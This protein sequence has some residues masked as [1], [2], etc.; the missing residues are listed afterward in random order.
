[1]REVERDLGKQWQI[2]TQPIRGRIDGSLRFLDQPVNSTHRFDGLLTPARSPCAELGLSRITNHVDGNTL[3][4]MRDG[5]RDDLA[6]KVAHATNY[7][8]DL[9]HGNDAGSGTEASPWHTLTRIAGPLFQLGDA[10][11]F[12]FDPSVGS[13]LISPQPDAVPRSLPC[14]APHRPHDY[15]A[16]PPIACGRWRW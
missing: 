2:L 12:I 9:V 6:S 10:T 13:K 15:A 11:L 14:F 4:D 7:Y 16:H 8:L 1:V 3:R 5:I